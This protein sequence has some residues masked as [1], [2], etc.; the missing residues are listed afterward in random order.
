MLAR[1]RQH[2]KLMWVILVAI[3][4][5]AFGL[6]AVSL[7]GGFGAGSEPALTWE[8]G[9]VDTN[10]YEGFARRWLDLR[11]SARDYSE[12][13]LH[14]HIVLVT[15]AARV[16]IRVTDEEVETFLVQASTTPYFQFGSPLADPMFADQ[17]GFYFEFFMLVAQRLRQASNAGPQTQTVTW[18]ATVFDEFVRKA[19]PTLT[20][21]EF[22]E[23]VR[24]DLVI[25]KFRRTFDLANYASTED[26]YRRLA[27]DRKE[28]T[29]AYAVGRAADHAAAARATAPTD[30]QLEAHYQ[31][32]LNAFAEPE[33]R[34]V[35]LLLCELPA[36]ARLVDV[37]DAEAK[38]HYDKH[39]DDW[40]P[41]RGAKPDEGGEKKDAGGDDKKEGGGGGDTLQEPPADPA[42]PAE[43][44]KPA[45]PD[46]L[47]FEQVKRQVVE[48]V[49]RERAEHAAETC[50]H[51]LRQ[52]WAE[53]EAGE[54]AKSRDPLLTFPSLER[55]LRVVNKNPARYLPGVTAYRPVYRRITAHRSAAALRANAEGD[56]KGPIADFQVDGGGSLAPEIAALYES[57]PVGRIAPVLSTE[58]ARALARFLEREAER[59]PPFADIKDTKVKEQW[60]AEQALERARAACEAVRTD[61]QAGKPLA[62]AAAA[63]GCEHRTSDFFMKGATDPLRLVAIK[64]LAQS[65]F[66]DGPE[67]QISAVIVDSEQR[68]AV[69]GTVTGRRTPKPAD[70]PPDGWAT[71]LP[72]L[73]GEQ[74][75][76]RDRRFSDPDTLLAEYKVVDHYT[77]RRR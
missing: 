62:E 23:G 57:L 49:R 61:A 53:D 31:K 3:T 65:P 12:N 42:K 11:R 55:M 63:H 47:P 15:E 46:L 17:G 28:V 75:S 54:V 51:T 66:F 44:A 37:S 71:T 18:N 67:G 68:V 7:M 69:V 40:R 10:E 34:T 16:G 39:R 1:M 32:A 64:A 13:D 43:P 52:L 29:V 33:T 14:A 48:A 2:E 41:S 73:A 38:E 60:F 19:W 26:A 50:L 5:P 20:L 25:T 36:M 8:G 74:R 9:Q 30:E 72:T 35:E 24:E 21:R 27:N 76:L 58:S 77:G 6:P 45:D 56:P 59:K 22:R 4:L 70:I